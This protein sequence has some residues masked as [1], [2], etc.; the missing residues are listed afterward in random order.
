MKHSTAASNLFNN[1]PSYVLPNNNLPELRI[2][3]KFK[4]YEKL[5]KDREEA[6]NSKY[7]D[8]LATPD[9]PYKDIPFGLI[10]TDKLSWA[11]ADVTFNDKKVKAK[12]INSNFP[13]TFCYRFLKKLFVCNNLVTNI[14]FVVFCFYLLLIYMRVYD[15]HQIAVEIFSQL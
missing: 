15:K 11:K 3:I 9:D 6:L 1:F 4:E 2:D 7:Y 13:I 14:L 12:S 5:R 8:T 10:V